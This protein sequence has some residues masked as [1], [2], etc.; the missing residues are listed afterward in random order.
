[1]TYALTRSA[2]DSFTITQ[3]RYIGA[4]VGADLRMLANLYGK[5]PLDHIDDYVEEVALL[6]RDGY[7]GTVDFG[8]KELNSN[9]WRLRLRYT[10]TAGG[11]LQD[12]RPG[13]FPSS[14]AVAGLPFYS[15]LNYSTKFLLL[16]T[17]ERERITAGLPVQRGEAN[18]PT[19]TAGTFT[20]GHG[21]ARNGI[22]VDRG[23][24]VAW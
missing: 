18:E 21:Y 22:G 10:A 20:S 12:S 11:H 15:F 4:K 13:S 16:A 19:A 6:L 7:L 5:P 24:Y 9:A 1:M 3:A 17:S 14:A 2:S 8:F 23:V